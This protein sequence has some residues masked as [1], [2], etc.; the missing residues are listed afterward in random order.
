VAVEL[1]LRRHV[2]PTLGDLPLAGIKPATLQEWVR[3]MQ[4]QLAPSYVRLIFTNLSTIF[5]AAVED[6][7]LARSPCRSD[8]ISLPGVP[9]RRISPWP[10]ARVEAVVTAHP[11]RYRAVP[12]VAAGCGLRQGECFG[13]R[14]Q[15]IDFERRELHV[16][17]QIR[18]IGSAPETALPKY[19]K[20]RMVP[21]PAWVANAL[22]AQL[23]DYPPLPGPLT[24]EPGVGGLV[25]YGR[26]RKPLNRSYFNSFIWKPALAKV[27]VPGTRA[28]GFHA[29]RHHCASVWLEHGVNIK[30]VSEYL[31]HSDPGFTLRTYTH[32]MPSADDKARQAID[33]VR[34]GAP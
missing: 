18:L 5:G 28:N 11:D 6:E 9:R 15:D 10:V 22:A 3:S 20:T 34:L 33:G 17:Q 26:E 13:L 25:F 7:V 31:G 30:A 32:V 24:E 19:R 2:L 23:R 8:R 14:V 16:R 21:M 1:R 4:E 12:V 29:L 27:E